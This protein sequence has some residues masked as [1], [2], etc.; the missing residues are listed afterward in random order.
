MRFIRN[1]GSRYTSVRKNASVSRWRYGSVT[2]GLDPPWVGEHRHQTTAETPYR[3]SKHVRA[4]PNPKSAHHRSKTMSASTFPH[5][6]YRTR[7]QTCRLKKY[8]PVRNQCERERF[9]YSGWDNSTSG[10]FRFISGYVLTTDV[11]NW[12]SGPK[13]PSQVSA[14]IYISCRYS[15]SGLNSISGSTFLPRPPRARDRVTTM[16]EDGPAPGRVTAGVGSVSRG[17]G[18]EPNSQDR[19]V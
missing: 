7:S 8:D 19:S 10:N 17:A 12:Y 15:T 1:I 5:L 9:G 13:P 3:E 16:A 2:R 18:T 6:K 11:G 14:G 4:Q